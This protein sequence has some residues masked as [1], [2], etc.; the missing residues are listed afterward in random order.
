M[1]WSVHS[2]MWSEIGNPNNLDKIANSIQLSTPSNIPFVPSYSDRP[3]SHKI[4]KMSNC[5]PRFSLT[6]Y[7]SL[8]FCQCRWHEIYYIHELY[9][10]L[11]YIEFALPEY[12]YGNILWLANVNGTALV[13]RLGLNAR[14]LCHALCWSSKTNEHLLNWELDLL[15]VKY[16]SANIK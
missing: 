16:R 4:I 13:Q 6:V 1:L 8:L 5:F 2:L 3:Q 15:W 12:S 9:H 14:L 7:V 10:S 11:L